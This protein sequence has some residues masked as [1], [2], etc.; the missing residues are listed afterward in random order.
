MWLKWTLI[1]VWI[2]GAILNIALIGKKRDPIT[3]SGAILVLI[4]NTLLIMGILN[5]WR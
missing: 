1:G 5:Y 2:L 4:I 3:P